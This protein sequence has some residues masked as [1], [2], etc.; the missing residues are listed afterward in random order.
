MVAAAHIPVTR[1][2]KDV[3]TERLTVTPLKDL[4]TQKYL[5]R[6]GAKEYHEDTPHRCEN[7]RTVAASAQAQG[8]Q[9]R[10][11]GRGGLF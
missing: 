10:A 1:K 9:R 11:E 7:H 2:D 3:G 5:G 8:R 6:S 4:Q